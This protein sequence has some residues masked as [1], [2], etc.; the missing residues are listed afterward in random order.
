[1]S[2]RYWVCDWGQKR[3]YSPITGVTDHMH[4]C[5]WIYAACV[6]ACRGQKRIGLLGAWVSSKKEFLEQRISYF[7]VAVPGHHDQ[8]LNKKVFQGLEAV[9][10]E[11]SHAAETVLTAED[12]GFQHRSLWRPFSFS[13]HH[14]QLAL[15]TT[16]LCLQAQNCSY[17]VAVVVLTGGRENLMY[18]HSFLYMLPLFSEIFIGGRGMGA[19]GI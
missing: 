19:A 14:K 5:V 17:F 10:V 3:V 12:Q 15:L 18:C 8:Q 2:V 6:D 4:I 9:M 16:K 13:P 11:Q 7:S 1:M